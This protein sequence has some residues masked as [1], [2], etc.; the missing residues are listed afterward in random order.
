MKKLLFLV[1]LMLCIVP[2][3]VFGE[4]Y[5]SVSGD[6][7]WKDLRVIQKMMA[8]RGMPFTVFLQ[9]GGVG[10]GTNF[11]TRENVLTMRD[12]PLCEIGCHTHTHADLSQLS[13]KEL[14]DE[15]AH[16][17]KVLREEYGIVSA[18][19]APPYGNSS[20]M[21][22]KVAT[23]MGFTHV[24]LA[25]DTHLLKEMSGAQGINPLPL[26]HPMRISALGLKNPSV[27]GGVLPSDVKKTIELA[28]NMYGKQDVLVC[29]FMHKLADSPK[30]D[31]YTYQTEMFDSVLNVLEEFVRKG[32]I[33]MV[34]FS[35]GVAKK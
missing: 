31:P 25:W 32:E 28:Q 9:T 2:R 5:V 30:G 1:M 35:E 8:E 17:L 13:Q 27:E 22:E 4:V 15:L 24:R 21:V 12:D 6:D 3:G 14:R 11:L 16:S 29:F 23:E 33:T 18:A 20:P 10:K 7:A 26:S 19:L 34:T